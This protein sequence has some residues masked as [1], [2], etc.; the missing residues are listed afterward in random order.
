VSFGLSGVSVRF[1][2]VLA[3]DGVSLEVPAGE[4][5]S[6]V[7]G[8]GAGKSTALRCLVG[9]V[10]P[11][12][13]TVSRP[14]RQRIG[15]MSAASGVWPDLTVDENLAFVGGA[16]GLSSRELAERGEELL[17][18]AGL[19]QVGDR[20]VRNLS[21]GMRQKLGFVLSVLHRPELL[22]L[23]EPST[24]VDPVS[25]VELWRLI[26]EAATD[27]A[28]VVMATTYLDEAERT[29]TLHVLDRGRVLLFGAADDIAGQMPGSIDSVDSAT[30]PDRAWRRGTAIR[31]W[32]PDGD[33]VPPTGEQ[34]LHPDVEDTTIGCMLAERWEG[35]SGG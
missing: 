17:G 6:L 5:T 10:V 35:H 8:D 33:P 26:A 32:R 15:Y 24:G 23:D 9:L 2:D 29:N 3:L 4:I 1:G 16:F 7:G 19:A 31:Q 12:A 27:G 28:A 20:L 25:R 11:T 34:I 13:G 14:A 18:R 22:V 21:G 30:V